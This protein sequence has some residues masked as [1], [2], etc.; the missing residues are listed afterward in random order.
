[1]KKVDWLDS[2]SFDIKN[3]GEIM[4]AYKEPSFWDWDFSVD[5]KDLCH[6][7]LMKNLESGEGKLISSLL[8]II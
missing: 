5:Y 2:L 1:M 7:W 8:Y 6:Q 4:V 3:P